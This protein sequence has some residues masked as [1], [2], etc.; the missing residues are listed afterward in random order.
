MLSHYSTKINAMLIALLFGGVL[1]L[2][3]EFSFASIS[4]SIYNFVHSVFGLLVYLGGRVLNEAITVYVA[5]FGNVFLNEGVGFAVDKLWVVVRDMLNLLF[6][7]GLVFI[8]LRL[9][10]DSGNSSAKKML[11][12]LIAAGLLVNF[13]LLIS[14]T[15]VDFSNLAAAQ[16]ANGFE[17]RDGEYQVSTSFMSVLDLQS[18]YETRP[19]DTEGDN[20]DVPWGAIIGAMVL[21]TVAGFVFFAGGIL[22]IIRF[23]VLN[24]YLILSPLMFIGWI[25]PG[26]KRYTSEYWSGFLSR[27]FF[28]PAYILMIY[29]SYRVLAEMRNFISGD[30]NQAFSNNA[31]EASDSIESIS[32]FVL[33]IVFLVASLVI[34]QKMGAQ[35]ASAAV[36]F[37]NRGTNWARSKAIGGAAYLPRVGVNKL[38]E[39]GQRKVANLE[40]R[41]DRLGS[42]ARFSPVNKLLRNA[43]KATADAKLGTGSNLAEER[44]YSSET[45]ARAAQTSNEN[46]RSGAI[47][48]GLNSQSELA[49]KRRLDELNNKI[50]AGTTLTADE[51][52][53][54]TNLSGSVSTT[55]ARLAE[56]EKMENEM[57]KRVTELSAK[58]LEEMSSDERAKIA[59]HLSDAQV[60]T[61]AKSDKINESD[62]EKI[63]DARNAALSKV[64]EA[65]GEQFSATIGKFTSDQIEN[66]GEDWIKQNAQFLSSTQ[67]D[68]IG[69]NDNF[70]QSQKDSFTKARKDGHKQIGSAPTGPD[71]AK[72]LK[73]RK[74]S[75]IAQLPPEILTKPEALSYVD[76]NV[77]REIIKGG[78]LDVTER[79]ALANNII[80][81]S[82]TGQPADVIKK[83]DAALDFL[84]T[85]DGVR[86]FG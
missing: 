83:L 4:G 21:Y 53:E 73:G 67:M 26:M 39:I 13:S 75:E 70:T 41:N 19:N 85:V 3:P 34:A 54:H 14:K 79:R 44:K 58:Q 42:I 71:F 9:I 47:K 51:T 74:A 37:G 38:G 55:A 15:V 60:K 29:L 63:T 8:G 23:A 27:C 18:V 86:H 10:L 48:A 80:G 50:T 68:N 56:L 5:G 64:L 1:L 59:P 40:A 62:K 28:A 30:V 84:S 72:L 66:L 82:R 31:G 81:Y 46:T 52:L 7:F 6:I 76:T 32:F 65:S 78:H 17:Y 33:A 36:S 35:G 2:L 77:L 49:N 11:G 45:K 57:K 24:I 12:M 61:L 25:F 43:T 69:K 16:I 22:L 20:K